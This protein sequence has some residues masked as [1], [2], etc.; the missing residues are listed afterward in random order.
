MASLYYDDHR[1]L[2]QEFGT[3]GLA[4]RLDNGWVHDGIGQDEQAFI[5]GWDFF[6]LSTVDPDGMPTVSYKGGSQGFV[7][8]LDANTLVFPGLDGNGMFYSMGNIE[9]Q[10]KVGLLFI[11]FE[12]PHRVRVQG[13]AR[14]LRD[15]PLM[16]EYT[17]AKYLVR[18]EVT[19]AWV[20]CPRYIHKYKKVEQNRYVPV[21]EKET[22]LALWKRLDMVGDVI[23]EEDRT[24]VARE[25]QIELPEYE[26][27]VARGES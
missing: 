8:V 2:Q 5:E 10:S 9:G 4:E 12:T 13:H 14:M 16:A 22:P 24:R 18:V 20:N 21:P 26:A 15:D 23:S 7:K 11:D 19:K 3:V 27:R 25:G 1:R 6:F 17:E